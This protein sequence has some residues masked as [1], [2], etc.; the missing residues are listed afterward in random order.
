MNRLVPSVSVP[1]AVRMEAIP[2]SSRFGSKLGI[3]RVYQ[4]VWLRNPDYGVPRVTCS[5]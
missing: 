3:T 4:T 1:P 2:V 5:I